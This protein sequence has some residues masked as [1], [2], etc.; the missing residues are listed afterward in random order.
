MSIGN[1]YK[2]FLCFWDEFDRYFSVYYFPKMWTII[3]HKMQSYWY[4]LYKRNVLDLTDNEYVLLQDIIFFR[5]WTLILSQT[6]SS[7]SEKGLSQNQH[8]PVSLQFF[9]TLV[10]IEH[11]S[12]FFLYLR[13]IHSQNPVITKTYQ[14]EPLHSFKQSFLV[15]DSTQLFNR[16]TE[17]TV[18]HSPPSIFY[19]SS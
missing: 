5:Q 9:F 15:P 19:W 1:G 16:K 14:Q 8:L 4:I 6:S 12:R 11:F 18:L 17:I 3:C 7:S 10:V 2:S 13:K